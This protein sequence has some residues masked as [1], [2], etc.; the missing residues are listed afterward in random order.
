MPLLAPID[1]WGSFP[2]PLTRLSPHAVSRQ[3]RDLVAGDLTAHRDR[4]VP[5]V[6]DTAE[7]ASMPRASASATPPYTA[8]DRAAAWERRRADLAVLAGVAD[9]LA[10]VEHRADELN[11]RVSTLLE[12]A[13]AAAGMTTGRPPSTGRGDLRWPVTRLS[14]RR[15]TA[16][17]GSSSTIPWWAGSTWHIYAPSTAACSTGSD[18]D[19]GELRTGEPPATTARSE[20]PGDA[21]VPPADI[22]YAA[23]KVL[24][25]L[26]RQGLR[27]MS[28]D[29]MLHVL[30]EVYL[31]L[32][33]LRP[34]NHGTDAAV[35]V[36]VTHLAVDAGYRLDWT[37]RPTEDLAAAIAAAHEAGDH[38]ALAESSTR[39]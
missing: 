3:T 34:F 2:F 30:A 5:G 15:S 32:L 20:D 1:Q 10:D 24:G 36:F 35:R 33:A 4:P 29:T 11:R 22:Q 31:D 6:E 21:G 38:T 23:N 16:G 18:P 7:H 9:D 39:R 37:A 13:G 14:R 19:A 26:G 27:G 28:R 12:Q 8:A 25:A 17:S